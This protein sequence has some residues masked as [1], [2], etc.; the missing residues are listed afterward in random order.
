MRTTQAAADRYDAVKQYP[1]T[2]RVGGRLWWW[3]LPLVVLVGLWRLGAGELVPVPAGR[4]LG[5]F[6]GCDRGAAFFSGA[7]GWFA[8][9]GS[10]PLTTQSARSKT[11]PSAARRR[12]PTTDPA[13]RWRTRSAGLS[14]TTRAVRNQPTVGRMWRRNSRR[15]FRMALEENSSAGGPTNPVPSRP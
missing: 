12:S 1:K 4:D 15:R 3:A 9:T 7:W 13:I 6:L 14:A 8:V 5:D 2:G 11:S 10:I